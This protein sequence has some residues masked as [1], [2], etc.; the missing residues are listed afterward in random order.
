MH[1][2][3]RE[4]LTLLSFSLKCCLG[5]GFYQ[6]SVRVFPLAN[7]AADAS[8]YFVPASNESGRLICDYRFRSLSIFAFTF[9]RAVEL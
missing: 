1:Y 6:N 9:P 4:S 3:A 5:K 2:P 8:L 7:F